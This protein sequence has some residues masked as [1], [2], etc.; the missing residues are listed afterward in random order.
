MIK[1]PRRCVHQ[2]E[3]YTGLME[4]FEHCIDCGY[5][6]MDIINLYDDEFLEENYPLQYKEILKERGE[7]EREEDLPLSRNMGPQLKMAPMSSEYDPL[8]DF[9][10]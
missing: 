5:K 8:D 9:D 1:N 10:F 2:W 3:L 6:R 7:Y 4:Q